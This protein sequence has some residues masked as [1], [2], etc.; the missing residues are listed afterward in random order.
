[1]FTNH[2]KKKLS[3]KHI[4]EYKTTI[5]NNNEVPTTHK[6][7]ASTRILNEHNNKSNYS[8]CLEVNKYFFIN[9][10]T[11]ILKK[12]NELTEMFNI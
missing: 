10:N 7:I 5:N 11:S 12:K 4:N 2:K 3:L 9:N 8:N 1:L 6:T